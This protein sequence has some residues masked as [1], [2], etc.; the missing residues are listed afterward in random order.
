MN[1]WATEDIMVSLSDGHPD[2]TR[3]S[4]IKIGY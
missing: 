2:H 3:R 1:N 4:T